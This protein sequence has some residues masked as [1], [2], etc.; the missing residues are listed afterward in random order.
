MRLVLPFVF[1]LLL[2]SCLTLIQGDV[3][4]SVVQEGVVL[5]LKGISTQWNPLL[6]ERLPRLI[7]L[8]AA[9]ASLAVSGA[10]MQALFQNPLAS[11]SILGISCGG[12]LLVVLIYAFEFHLNHPYMVAI[13]AVI[14]CFL[15]LL[16]VYSISFFSGSKQMSNLIL[17]GIAVSTLIIAIQGALLYSLRDH[18]RLIQTVTEWE[19][20]SSLDRTWEH[21]HLQLPL[22]LTGLFGALYYRK[23]VDLLALGD[24]E[25]LNL[26]VE[27]EKVRWRLFISVALLTGGAIAGI[28][29]IA[30]FG[31]LLPHVLRKWT[32]P[33]NQTLI[34][35]C[36]LGGGPI[37]L[38][39]DLALRFFKIQMFTIGNIS[40]ILGGLFFFILLLKQ[41][42]LREC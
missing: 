5:R 21:V 41:N 34:P 30:F 10:V 15:T 16:I 3:P 39:L 32:G 14:G 13:A 28:G 37:L 33:S 1:L 6:D 7:V 23:E 19:A 35:C 27:V 40:A 29:M 17:A 2:L 11:P 12:S 8:L 18:W 36:L 38:G 20:G 9:G 26:G 22:T 42:R 25:A 31:L 4:W 24:E